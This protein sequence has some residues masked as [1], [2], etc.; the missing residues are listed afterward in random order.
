MEY[1]N[2]GDL[3]NLNAVRDNLSEGDCKYLF[4]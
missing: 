3:D 2:G 1:C 4:T